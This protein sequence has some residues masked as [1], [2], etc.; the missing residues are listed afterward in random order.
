MHACSANKT[1][2]C[3]ISIPAMVGV[4]DIADWCYYEASG[5]RDYDTAVQL[6][7]V[8]PAYFEQMTVRQSLSPCMQSLADK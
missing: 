3:S 7:H 4:T 6:A 5:L 1:D 2:L 8:S